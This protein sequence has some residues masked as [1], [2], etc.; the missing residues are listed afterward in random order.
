MTLLPVYT[1]ELEYCFYGE[2]YDYIEST[3]KFSEKEARFYFNQLINVLQ[4][5]HDLGYA[6]RDIKIENLLLGEDFELKLAD[7]GFSTNEQL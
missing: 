1:I 5:M 2:L 6:H 4:Y 7:F 3:G